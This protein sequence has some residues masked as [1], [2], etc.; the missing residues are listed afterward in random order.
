MK[1]NGHNH[2]TEEQGDVSLLRFMLVLILK[3]DMFY[4][5]NPRHLEC[6][7]SQYCQ[8]VINNVSGKIDT[9]FADGGY[10]SKDA[11]QL[12][13]LDTKVVVPPR[14]NAVADK[15]THQRNKAINCINE[16]RKSRWKRKYNYH[17]RALVE[18]LFSRWKTIYGENIRSKNSEAQ[19]TEVTLKSFILNKMTDLGMPQWKRIYFLN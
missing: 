6:P 3:L 5:I 15:H 9:L 13:E 12:T 7:T 4:S 16:H 8:S 10:D 11:Y 19:Q 2:S 18:N 1:K 17:K 14:I